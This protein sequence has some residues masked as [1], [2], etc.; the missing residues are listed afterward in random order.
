MTIRMI[1]AVVGGALGLAGCGT[2]YI[3]PPAGA[4]TATVDFVRP[5]GSTNPTI[6][7][8]DDAKSCSGAH[9]A[10]KAADP[11]RQIRVLAGVPTALAARFTRA[12]ATL[13]YSCG[14][15]VTF[16]PQRGKQYKMTASYPTNAHV[17]RAGVV[18]SDDGKSWH[19]LN[20]R[21]RVYRTNVSLGTGTCPDLTDADVAFMRDKTRSEDGSTTLSD[22]SDLLTP[23]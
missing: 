1:A 14:V 16:V 23:Q 3:E 4:S 15:S 10:L 5:S 19:P 9:T 6:L 13:V 8:F 22:L 11:V 7:V 20:V 2:T 18:E 21:Y 17:C 12:S